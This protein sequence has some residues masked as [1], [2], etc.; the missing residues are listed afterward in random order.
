MYKALD[1]REYNKI[2]KVQV[3][4]GRAPN[5]DVLVPQHQRVIVIAKNVD[6]G[7]RVRFEF[8]ERYEVTFGDKTHYGG[9]TGDYA[10]IVPGDYFEVESGEDCPHVSIAM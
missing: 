4:K 7:K 2:G 9:Y 6:T 3:F 5:L 10:M 8:Y 1:V